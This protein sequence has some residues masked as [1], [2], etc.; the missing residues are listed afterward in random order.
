MVPSCNISEKFE[1]IL[2]LM[3]CRVRAY[4][5]PRQTQFTARQALDFLEAQ[6]PIVKAK[7][8]ERRREHREAY[9]GGGST[10]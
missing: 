9:H 5:W 4:L 8:D 7:V 3:I 10:L 2:L 1:P 6:R